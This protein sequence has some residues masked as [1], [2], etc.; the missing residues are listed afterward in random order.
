MARMRDEIDGGLLDDVTRALNELHVSWGVW[1]RS[2]KDITRWRR[3]RHGHLVGEA[4]VVG[5]HLYLIAGREER[6]EAHDQLRMTLEEI[7][8]SLND[9]RSIDAL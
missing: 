8:H 9:A 2:D 5:L 1:L 3:H 6:V 7:R 4:L